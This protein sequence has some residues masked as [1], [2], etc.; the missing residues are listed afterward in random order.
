MITDHHTG[1]PLA[2]YDPSVLASDDDLAVVSP[3]LARPD[4]HLPGRDD[5]DDEE[6]EDAAL[7]EGRTIADLES[8]ALADELQATGLE[9]GLALTQS[10]MDDMI[11]PNGYVSEH[12]PPYSAAPGCI[13]I[14][15]SFRR[16]ALRAAIKRLQRRAKRLRRA[17]DR[18]M[19]EAER[20]ESH[21]DAQSN[22]HAQRSVANSAVR[23]GPPRTTDGGHRSGPDRLQALIRA[24]VR[25]SA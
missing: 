13:Y 11:G 15:L 19:N 25:R 23:C 8:Q 21:A 17:A 7:A 9:V 22:R 3:A 2:G 1:I 24:S 4:R 6:L 12:R 16:G 20:S 5:V 10:T 18:L 14:H